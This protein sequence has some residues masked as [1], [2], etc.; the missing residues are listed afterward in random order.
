[1]TSLLSDPFDAAVISSPTPY[2]HGTSIFSIGGP[3]VS[4]GGIIPLKIDAG[5]L[6]C[7]ESEDASL[8]PQVHGFAG[9]RDEAP[10]STTLP[11]YWL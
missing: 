2:H 6:T 7:C 4:W 11:M 10:A 9:C 1:M 5:F 8:L 3:R